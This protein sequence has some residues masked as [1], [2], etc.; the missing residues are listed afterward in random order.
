[1]LVLVIS[2]TVLASRIR[3]V[4][5]YVSKRSCLHG[6]WLII[7]LSYFSLANVA[8]SFMRCVELSPSGAVSPSYRFLDDPG[9]ACYENPHLILFIVSCLLAGLFIL[10]FP[11]VI[12]LLRRSSRFKPFA[13]ICY[14]LYKDS[15]WWWCA[16]DLQRRLLFT[17]INTFV[18]GQDNQTLKSAL[19]IVSAVLV[20]LVHGI[21]WPYQSHFENT[22]ESLLLF[23]LCC[24]S[25]ISAGW[26]AR[27]DSWLAADLVYIPW[28][29]GLGVWTYQHRHQL[30]KLIQKIGMCTDY[31]MESAQA[32][33][34]EPMMMT[35]S[36]MVEDS[37]GMEMLLRRRGST[38]VLAGLRDPLLEEEGKA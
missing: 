38:V 1:M 26:G 28:L 3:R 15:R 14:S 27:Q 16:L 9:L 34:E 33:V 11:I 12:L 17:L 30:I 29:V 2:F 32:T 8:F 4:S 21:G 10:P 19:L 22:F 36:D 31:K 37:E 6:V 18:S 13:D 25:V 7:L 23:N 5:R 24:L 35:Q 20:L